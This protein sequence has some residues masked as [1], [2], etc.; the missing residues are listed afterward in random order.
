MIMMTMPSRAMRLSKYQQHLLKAVLILVHY[1]PDGQQVLAL[2]A[3]GICGRETCD[4]LLTAG[5]A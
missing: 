5:T 1:G 2:E 4:A 3:C